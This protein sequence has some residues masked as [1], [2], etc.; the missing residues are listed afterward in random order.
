M[1]RISLNAFISEF[2]EVEAVSTEIIDSSLV[3][4]TVSWGVFISDLK[5]K[6]WQNSWRREE[7]FAMSVA[8]ERTDSCQYE[9]ILS[10]IK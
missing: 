4:F 1:I 2:K 6:Q 8:Q 9:F 10:F 3:V 7:K 5:L